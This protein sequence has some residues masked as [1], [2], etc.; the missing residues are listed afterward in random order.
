M[1]YAGASNEVHDLHQPNRKHTDQAH[2]PIKPQ[3]QDDD[4]RDRNEHNHDIGSDIDSAGRDE[5][6][7]PV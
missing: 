5:C 7:V 4:M 1:I 6:D 3:L 2:L